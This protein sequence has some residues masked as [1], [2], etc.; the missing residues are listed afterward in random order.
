[1]DE[2]EPVGYVD[3]LRVYITNTPEY[4][5]GYIDSDTGDWIEEVRDSKTHAVIRRAVNGQLET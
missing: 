2:R 5:F 4:V 1:M 3:G